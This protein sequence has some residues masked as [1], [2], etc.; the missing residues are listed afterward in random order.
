MFPRPGAQQCPCGSGAGYGACCEPLHDGQP[1]PTA[2]ALMRGR[3]CA[4]AT[5]RLDYILATWHP[6]TRPGNL[7]PT[8]E[9][10]W[11]GLQVV[12]T[13]DGGLGDERGTVEFRASFRA[14]GRNQVMHET[15]TFVRRG[16]RW[17]YVGAD[18]T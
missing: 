10:L 15:S 1:A 5:G 8:P 9:V 18:I 17:V 14:E 6:R 16:G 2:E 7:P 11:A 3:Y 4:F 13:V 12:R